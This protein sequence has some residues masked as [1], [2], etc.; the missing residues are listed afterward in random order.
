MS[1]EQ[2]FSNDRGFSVDIWGPA[3]WHFLRCMA[4]NFP[5]KPVPEKKKREY[6]QFMV[7][8]GHVLP[9]GPCRRSY[10]ENFK[11]ARL[12]DLRNYADRK[13]FSKAVNDLERMINTKVLTQDKTKLK[14]PKFEE[15][16]KLYTTF[17]AQPGAPDMPCRNKKRV[18]LVVVEKESHKGELSLQ[19]L[20]DKRAKG[21]FVRGL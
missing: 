7:S 19:D 18:M 17:R 15:T 2:D 8:L 13:T 10:E 12:D 20:S 1:R 6:M 16:H 21:R 11:K 9:C 3:A 5:L 4:F 14:A